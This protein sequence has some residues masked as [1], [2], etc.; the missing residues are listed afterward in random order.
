[1]IKDLIDLFRTRARRGAAASFAPVCMPARWRWGYDPRFEP[2]S[3]GIEWIGR[4]SERRFA[5]ELW[6]V[7]DR[8][9]H[10]WPDPPEFAFWALGRDGD[11]RCAGDFDGW[12]RLWRRTGEARC[13]G[14][15]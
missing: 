3:D 8:L 5:G 9:W 12:P 15:R 1:M 10:G 2:Y 13:D 11:V 6:L 7:G 4:P 14:A